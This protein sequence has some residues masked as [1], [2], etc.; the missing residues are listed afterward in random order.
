V[1][2][3]IEGAV[4]PPFADSHCPLMNRPYSFIAILLCVCARSAANRAGAGG[5]RQP[6][7]CIPTRQLGRPVVGADLMLALSGTQQIGRTRARPRQVHED[8]FARA[9]LLDVDRTAE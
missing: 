5:C 1:A 7:N 2:G 9:N 8:G 4:F 6:G 3:L